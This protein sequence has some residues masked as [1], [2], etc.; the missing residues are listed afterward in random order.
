MRILD[1]SP[2]VVQP[3]V[4]GSSVRT[5]NLLVR[6]AERHEVRQFSQARLVGGSDPEGGRGTNRVTASYTE[7]RFASP[8]ATVATEVGARTWIRAP[9]LSGFGLGLAR[10]LGRLLQWAEVVIVEF[11]WQFGACCR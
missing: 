6:L 4:R 1:V 11:P 9:V 3:P 2:R 10:P 5:A 7:L 8:V